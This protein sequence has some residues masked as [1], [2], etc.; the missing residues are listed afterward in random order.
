[1]EEEEEDDD[2]VLE[3]DDD[4]AAVEVLSACPRASASRTGTM[5]S[6]GTTTAAVD[7][8][9]PIY[10]KAVYTDHAMHKHQVILLLLPGGVGYER[11]EGMVLSLAAVDVLAVTI[12]WPEWII[13]QEFLKFLKRQLKKTV[14]ANIDRMLHDDDMHGASALEDQFEENFILM[15]HAIKKQMA[16]I[17]PIGGVH[18]STARIQLDMP[19]AGLSDSEWSFFG[20]PHGVRML[21]VD[22]LEASADPV[23]A[24]KSVSLANEDK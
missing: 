1:M 14:Q 16:A 12:I 9:N 5:V 21:W 2:D 15:Q 18:K 11:T 3:V 17:C 23:T 22:L 13:S 20:D 10:I 19:V 24:V 8:W 7:S 6:T 4:D